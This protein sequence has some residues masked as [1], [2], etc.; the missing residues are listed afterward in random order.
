LADGTSGKSVLEEGGEVKMAIAALSASTTLT[1]LLL[2]VSLKKWTDFTRI[3]LALAC[4][5]LCFDVCLLMSAKRDAVVLGVQDIEKEKR[6]REQIQESLLSLLEET[7][8]KLS[9]QAAI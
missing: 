7:C 8:S 2:V 4:M 6:E 3:L 5:Q 1:M 9:G